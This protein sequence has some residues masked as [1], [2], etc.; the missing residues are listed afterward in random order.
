MSAEG[1]GFLRRYWRLI[2]VLAAVTLAFVLA[3]LWRNILLPFIIGLILAYLLHPG[4]L[5]LE[6]HLPPKGKY[7]TAK[8]II[9]IIVVCLIALGLGG[10]LL[11]FVVV[12]ASDAFS[13]LIAD[14]PEY[15]MNIWDSFTQW[16]AT[17]ESQLPPQVH[18][19]LEGFLNNLP[20][21][22][23]ANLQSW[24]GGVFSFI[25]GSLNGLLGFVALP[26]FLF[27]ILKD[28]ERLR[29]GF[30][31]YT[32]SGAVEHIKNIASIVERT[33]GRYIRAALV[34]AFTVGLLSFIGLAILDIPYAPALAFLAGVTEIIPTI[35]P[36]IG[37]AI[38][39][40]VTLGTA[41][42]KALWVAVLFVGV[43]LLENNLLVPRIQG[44]FMNINPAL[45]LVLLV[46]GAYLGGIWGIVLAVPL[47]AVL[48]Q[49]Y[50]YVL[51]VVRHRDSDDK[52]EVVSP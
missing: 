16:F 52:E 39:F 18:E 24:L 12:A 47:T 46:L 27:Y 11:S 9:S 45:A 37:G 29:E 36:W 44:Q 43:Q 4:V 40:I 6:R 50:L 32:P 21:E 17:L 48:A 5:W 2:A 41:P 19:G 20:A 42:T 25:F 38:A 30:Y 22:L 31:R 10:Y 49:V 8:R 3:Y 51:R 1:E 23:G 34:L 14:A 26:L 7:I 28:S 33:L 13:R 15:L 35:G